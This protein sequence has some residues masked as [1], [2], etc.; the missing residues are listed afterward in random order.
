MSGKNASSGASFPVLFFLRA[1]SS[2]SLKIKVKS[3]QEM[4]AVADDLL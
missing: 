4:F 1:N 2:R 3:G